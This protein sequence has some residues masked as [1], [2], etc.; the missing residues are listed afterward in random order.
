M[1]KKLFF[2]VLCFVF[3]LPL[4]AYP[5]ELQRT[6]EKVGSWEISPFVGWYS[7]L[8]DSDINLKNGPVLGGRVGYNFTENLALEFVGEVVGSQVYS[9]TERNPIVA[10]L[11]L[12][13][14][15]NGEP[16]PFVSPDD[17]VS[18]QQYHLDLLWNFMPRERFNPFIAVGAG[19]ADFNASH[20]G[21]TNKFVAPVG[22]GA[23]YWMTDRVAFRVDL[24][25]NI[26]IGGK[27][28]YP[29]EATAG[30]VFAFGK[31]IPKPTPPPPPP[32]PPTPAPTPAPTPMPTP[33]PTP[34]PAPTPKAEPKKEVVIVLEDVHFDFDK[35]TLTK[36]A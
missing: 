19:I 32:P 2:V 27:P 13:K 29:V 11:S 4:S 22:V 7:F 5:E 23:K 17:H 1:F 18:L 26:M 25:D 10:P 21:N 28:L 12:F 35:A 9:K 6:I 30:I 36:E 14:H 8:G 15:K 16:P 31:A 34:T 33:K 3:L 24:K 20:T